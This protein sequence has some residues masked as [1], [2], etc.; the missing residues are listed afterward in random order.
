MT[1]SSYFRPLLSQLKTLDF[2]D[3]VECSGFGTGLT[4]ACL[5]V[6][7]KGPLTLSM[8]AEIFCTVE[9]LIGEQPNPQVD[10]GPQCVCLPEMIYKP[11]PK[12]HGF[13]S[14]GYM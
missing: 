14:V 9:K 12:V 10:L 8:I 6:D 7:T 2:V 5:I 3:K 4:K 1:Y 13:Y 11:K